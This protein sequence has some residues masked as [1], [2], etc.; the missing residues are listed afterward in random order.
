MTVKY[1]SL[2]GLILDD[3]VFPDGRTAMGS[4]G[5]GGVYTAAGMR[6]WSDRIGLWGRA[7]PDFDFGLLAPLDL[8]NVSVRANEQPTPRAWQLYEEDGHRTQIPRISAEVWWTQ[9]GPTPADLPPLAGIRG[10]H[11]ST[12][13]LEAEPEVVAK[14]IEAGLTLSIEPIIGADTP[15]RQRDTMFECLSLADI[16]SPGLA[17]ARHLLGE[18]P[19]RELLARFAKMGP[20]LIILRQG[21]RGSLVYDRDTDHH[22]LVPAARAHVVDVTGGG[23]AYCGGFLVGW[24]EH[25]DVVRAAARAAISAAI[26]LE[27]VG[28]PAIT[29]VLLEEAQARLAGC[30]AQINRLPE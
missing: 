13:G 11:M 9:L 30:L 28:P 22:W 26:T 3:I 24:V 20:R 4:L 29:P 10:V 2:G 15:A 23:N 17:D 8:E 27:Q 12:R 18:R 16:F 25:G 21:A 7:G 19:E 5:G 6:L 1:L 14:L